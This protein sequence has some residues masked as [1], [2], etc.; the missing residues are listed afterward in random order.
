MWPLPV[1]DLY[2]VGHSSAQRLTELGIRTIG[3]LACADPEF[4]QQH[5]KSH[6]K[7]MWEYANGID[8][9]RL[10]PEV[11]ELK[12]IGNSTTLSRDALTA[13]EA[14][15]RAALPGGAGRRTAGA[16]RDRSPPPSPWKSS[17]VPS[18]PVPGR[19]SCIR[20]RLSP[21]RC[22]NAP[23]SFFDQLWNGSP[24]PSS[25]PSHHEAPAQGRSRYSSLCSASG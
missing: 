11:H 2:M 1:G 7:M 25:G 5:F 10:D 19:P 23:A 6:G 24:H 13:Q 14:K 9:S 18:S 16:R 20:P 21:T 15:T 12:G 22:M 3:D 4:L 17:T 8:A